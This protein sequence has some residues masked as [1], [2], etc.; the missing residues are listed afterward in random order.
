MHG[1]PAYLTGPWSAAP[2]LTV[3]FPFVL[4]L[5]ASAAV[6]ETHLRPVPAVQPSPT[7]RCGDA[8]P[9]VARGT[10]GTGQEGKCAEGGRVVN[11]CMWFI[12][13]LDRKSWCVLAR[14]MLPWFTVVMQSLTCWWG[15]PV[16]FP[17]K[18]GEPMR[19]NLT[20]YSFVC[21]CVCTAWN[22]GGHVWRGG[23]G[24]DGRGRVFLLSE[25][26]GFLA[27]LGGVDVVFGAMK[28]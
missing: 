3:F 11:S 7:P 27:G 13:G 26:D 5:A 23:G 19:A 2:F 20:F 15:G 18:E 6:K 8:G 10:R 24:G 12:N 17:V 14:R 4:V 9:A 16:A 28:S 22:R 25:M 1:C 21:V